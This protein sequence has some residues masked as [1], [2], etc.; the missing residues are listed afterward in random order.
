MIKSRRPTRIHNRVVEA[1]RSLGG[2]TSIEKIDSEALSARV[3]QD[4]QRAALHEVTKND[5]S[6]DDQVPPVQ[7]GLADDIGAGDSRRDVRPVSPL[8]DRG[9][10]KDKG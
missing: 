5:D 8:H 9:D 4:V 2:F 1:F 10:S 7:E 6:R 3:A